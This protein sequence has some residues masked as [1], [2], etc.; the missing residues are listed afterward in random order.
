MFEDPPAWRH[1]V[2]KKAYTDGSKQAGLRTVRN[3]TSLA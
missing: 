1:T 2:L 3:I